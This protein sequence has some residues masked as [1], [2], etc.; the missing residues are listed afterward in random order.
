MQSISLFQEN[1]MIDDD[2]PQDSFKFLGLEKGKRYHQEKKIQPKIR[3]SLKEIAQTLSV[4]VT[5]VTHS[6]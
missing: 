6:H 1:G 5:R 4:E 3:S 2:V